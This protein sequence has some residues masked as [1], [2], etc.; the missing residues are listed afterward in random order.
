MPVNDW[1]ENFGAPIKP[2]D[3]ESS[4]SALVT[5]VV[6]NAANIAKFIEARRGQNSELV[7]FEFKTGKPQDAV[8]PIQSV[9]CIGVRFIDQIPMPI[10]YILRDNFPDTDHQY[11]THEGEPP[12]IC[13]DNRTWDEA[14]LTWTPAEFIYRT[15]SWFSRAADG[16][17]HARRQPLE[18]VFF[19][20]LFRFF[21][22]RKVLNTC[23][24]LDLI[25]IP[26]QEGTKSYQISPIK[27]VEE[28][29]K[30]MIPICIIT[31]T[32][33][34][35]KMRRLTSLP[36]SFSSLTRL[37]KDRGVDLLV[38]LRELIS[39]GFNNDSNFAW[40]INSLFGVILEMP[41]IAPEGNKHN[42][43]DLR[44]F[45]TDKNSIGEIAVALGVALNA[46]PDEGSIAG[47]VKS[48]SP[49]EVDQ[50]ALNKI[51]VQSAEVQYEFDRHLATQISGRES[52]DDR[53]VVMV[54]AGAIGSHISDCLIREGRFQWTIIDDDCLL[55]HNLARHTCYKNDIP[56]NKALLVARNLST[57]LGNSPSVARSIPANVMTCNS[58]RQEI[59]Q[60]LVEAELIIDATASLPAERYISDHDATARRICIFF[61][62]SGDAAVLLVEPTDRSL[63]LRDLEA[64]YL[65]LVIRKSSLKGH[66]T[67]PSGT[68]TYT[69]SC[70]AITN[71][72]P[73]SH[74]MTLSG[75]I[76]KGITKA[77]DYEESR[78]RIWSLRSS[79]KVKLLQ[80][81][82]SLVERF[83]SQD[84]TVTINQGLIRHILTMRET[85]LPVETGGVLMGIV[86]IP[87]KKIQLVDAA[88]EPPDSKA[89]RY[90][91]ERGTS[92]VQEYFDHVSDQTNGQVRYVG[93]WHSHPPRVPARPSSTDLSQID[94]LSTLFEID[95]LPALMLI[96]ADDHVSIILANQQAQKLNIEECIFTKHS[97]D[98]VS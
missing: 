16:N 66:L 34:P 23:K 52:V 2:N 25:A 67:P 70:R 33:Q 38:D 22:S 98:H 68:Y 83:E 8:Y 95:N 64:Q 13:I 74:V 69:G 39:S 75:L 9:E 12:A 30:S 11:L 59:D 51:T 89:S 86:D 26:I 63:T 43:T 41:I 40:H 90:G 1:L 57:I 92:G 96:A 77:V 37:L 35:E 65:G 79:G 48:I 3:L 14:R 81:A 45:V 53:K 93:E 27:D 94:W 7:I 78:I 60:A 31:Y 20:S 82:V 72:I 71:F 5:F 36:S 17:L 19:H 32:I 61:N 28:F 47:F 56:H 50:D 54:G 55:P 58:A 62:P 4:A 44:A 91:F 24:N 97:E 42:G 80:P 29:D 18:P 84:W 85:K 49:R 46:K 21:I 10:V 88:Q 87:A 73:Q 15:L 76:S 6:R